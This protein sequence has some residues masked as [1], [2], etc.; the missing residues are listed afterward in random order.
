MCPKPLLLVDVDG[1]ISLFGFPSDERP[2]GGWLLV[3]GLPHLLSSAAAEHL[4]TLAADF[5][6]AWCTGWEEKAD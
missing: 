1:V 2:A 6:L 5:D 4:L 3:D